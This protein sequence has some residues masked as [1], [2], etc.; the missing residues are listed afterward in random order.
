MSNE[1]NNRRNMNASMGSDGESIQ[2]K[3]GD[4]RSQ[5]SFPDFNFYK[6]RTFSGKYADITGDS[7]LVQY[8]GHNGDNQNSL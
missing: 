2:N 5:I 6:I 7:L 3:I 8:N 4:S 1:N